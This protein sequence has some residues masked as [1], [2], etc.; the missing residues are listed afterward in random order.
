MPK[1]KKDK[2]L[3]KRFNEID[4]EKWQ[5]AAND[6]TGGNLTLWMELTLNR[7]LETI[8]EGDTI[9]WTFSKDDHKQFAGKTFKAEVAMVDYKNKQ[10]G[11]YA[12]YGQDLIPFKKATRVRSK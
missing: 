12:E 5:Q 2:P 8:R 3:T 11:V 9:K 1:K 6:A 7:E 10:Y 4:V